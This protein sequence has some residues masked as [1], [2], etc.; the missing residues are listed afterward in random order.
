MNT[1]INIDIKANVSEATQ[2]IADAGQRISASLSGVEDSGRNLT[3]TLEG[4]LPPLSDEERLQL[5][6][7]DASIRLQS[8]QAGFA[9]S[10]GQLE[11]G[12][13]RIWC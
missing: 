11:F 13:S 1:Q 10:S 8:A 4:S 6:N 12:Y 5:A 7:V 9:C 2:N 3:S